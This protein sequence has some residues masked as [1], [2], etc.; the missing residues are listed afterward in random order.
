VV[1]LLVCVTGFNVIPT[2]G[3]DSI[4]DNL[5]IG[6]FVDKIVYKVIANQDQRILAIQAGEIEMDTSFWDPVHLP[7][8]DSDPD[9]S[10]FSALRNGYGHITI[11]CRKYPLNISAFRRAFAFAFDKT[12]VTAEVMDGFSKEHDSLVPYVSGWCIEDDLPYH[13]YIEQADVGN[14]ILNDAGFIIDPV[15][16]YRLAPNGSSFDVVIEYASSSM[17]I[18]GGT[19]QIGVDA[20]RALDVN[21]RTGSSDYHEYISR[22]DSHRD[23]DMIFYAQDF[24]NNDVDWLAYSYWSEY[25]DTPYQNPTNFKN[26]TYDSWREQLLYGTSYEEVFEAAAEMQM[27]LHYNVPRLVVYE[28]TYMQGYRH[29]QFEGHIEDRSRYIAGPWTMRKIRP[30]GASHGGTVPIAIPADLETLNVFTGTSDIWHD[31]MDIIYSSLYRLDPKQ[32]PIGDLASNCII[33][34]NQNNPSVPESHQRFTLDIVQNSTWSDG[35]PLTAYDVASTFTYIL[36]SGAYDNPA[37]S[38]LRDLYA[39]YALEPGRVVIEFSTESYWHFNEFAFVKILP[40]HVFEDR[41]RIGYSSWESWNPVFGPSEPHVTC[42]P[43]IFTDYDVGEFYE[44]SANPDY[45]YYP[46][47]TVCVFPPR[48]NMEFVVGPSESFIQWS[49]VLSNQGDYTLYMDSI[50]VDQGRWDGEVTWD[51]DDLP[52]GTYEFTLEILYDGGLSESSTMTVDVVTNTRSRPPVTYAIS[53][54]ISVCSIQAIS[55]V[56]FV[57]YRERKEWLMHQQAIVREN[58][59]DYF[60]EVFGSKEG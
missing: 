60:A 13:Y 22:C 30:I 8:L 49:S 41:T 19:A 44:L 46:S 37:A 57:S 26:T 25:A 39:A 59:R 32:Y 29:D 38:S 5:K 33:E 4:L 9:I 7:T 28:N 48:E 20:L 45:Q 42:G 15:T 40:A 53:V 3:N 56:A 17:E 24:Y 6:P 14:Q 47:P 27:I 10:I 23:F 18:A 1:I 50:I 55:W 36:E 54:F 52:I 11:N 2:S 16:G 35:S 12:R 43:Y 51:I 31:V 34:T 21:A 58:Q